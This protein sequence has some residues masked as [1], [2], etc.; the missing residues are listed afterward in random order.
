VN[1][2]DG[3]VTSCRYVC[4]KEGHRKKGQRQFIEKCFRAETRTN[5]DARMTLTFHRSSGIIQVS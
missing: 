1:K 5:R 4:A 3:T 2:S